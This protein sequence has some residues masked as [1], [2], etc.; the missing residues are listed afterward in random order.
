MLAG[1]GRPH[2]PGTTQEHHKPESAENFAFCL[3]PLP[4]PYPQPQIQAKTNCV[5]VRRTVAAMAAAAAAAGAEAGAA[6]G[7]P[8]PL[9]LSTL[10]LEPTWRAILGPELQKPYIKE[11]GP[12]EG[13]R[14]GDLV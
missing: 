7:A 13:M 12:R 5:L 11:V 8:P 3:V 6:G 9:S 10:L 2:A 1:L 14:L 4:L